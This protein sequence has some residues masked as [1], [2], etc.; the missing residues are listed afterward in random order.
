[1]IMTDY[2]KNAI[3][4]TL[5]ESHV[6]VDES[7]LK[8]A[9]FVIVNGGVGSTLTDL[10]TDHIQQAADCN[11]PCIMDWYLDIN[12]YELMDKNKLPDFA[13]CA[14]VQAMKRAI[15]SG[16]AKRKIHALRLWLYNY[17]Y[18][19][20]QKETQSNYKKI[21]EHIRSLAIENFGLPVYIVVKQSFLDAFSKSGDELNTWISNTGWCCSTSSA[22]LAS[23]V[24]D[25]DNLPRP[26]STYAKPFV[27]N[28]ALCHFFGYA[29]TAKTAPFGKSGAQ[30]AVPLTMY[31]S[32]KTALYT[33][34]AFAPD[35]TTTP[36]V[37]D[38]TDTTKA[39]AITLLNEMKT[40]V[41]AQIDAVIKK[42]S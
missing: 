15:Y 16:T 13:S 18:S 30:V 12:D 39:D 26:A 31:Q 7:L 40:S 6:N 1:M 28:A 35:D 32:D 33:A 27:S 34:L 24:L 17:V 9:D 14:Q 5:N 4:V 8:K 25:W 42:L 23:G 37:T 2:T 21:A 19:D 22:G 10:L 3:G 29:N 36:V 20:G 11:I 38:P 41:D